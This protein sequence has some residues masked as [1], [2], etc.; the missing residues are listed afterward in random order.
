MIEVFVDSEWY[1]KQPLLEPLDL[2]RSDAD[3]L[4][5]TEAMCRAAEG[6]EP[7][8]QWRARQASRMVA[9]KA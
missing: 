3:I 5:A 9:Y 8:S 1:I 2:S 4:A 6:F 7:A